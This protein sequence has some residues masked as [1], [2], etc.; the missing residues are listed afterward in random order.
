MRTIKLPE[1]LC[2]AIE[3]KFSARFDS[4]EDFLAAA[5]KEF[6]RDD[7]TKMDEQEE[8]VIEERLKA[9]GYV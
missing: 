8:R 9:L 3:Q 2:Q 5:L 1:E 6:L 7:T 4:F